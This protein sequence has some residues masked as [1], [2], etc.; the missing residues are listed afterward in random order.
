M[1]DLPIPGRF[2]V[3]FSDVNFSPLTIFRFAKIDFLTNKEFFN[4][5]FVAFLVLKPID[6]SIILIDL[7][8]SL[9]SFGFIL[10]E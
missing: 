6:F 2:I 10:E 3:I 4:Y 1:G 8:I 7:T 9:N 5:N